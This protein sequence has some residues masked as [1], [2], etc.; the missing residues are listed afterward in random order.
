MSN[1][2]VYIH[3][4]HSDLLLAH[5]E[6]SKA[7]PNKEV[8]E[9]HPQVEVLLSGIVML[10]IPALPPRPG[11]DV[12]QPGGVVLLHPVLLVVVV[13]SQ[14]VVH[15]IVLQNRQHLPPDGVGARVV[16]S[17]VHGEV[18]EDNLPSITVSRLKL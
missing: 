18:A 14:V 9:L 3:K 1:V 2:P 13:P 6:M 15:V 5:C 11:D 8:L 17:R 12:L 4:S 7:I 10:V 16:T